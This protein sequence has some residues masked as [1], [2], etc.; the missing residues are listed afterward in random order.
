MSY[1]ERIATI[2]GGDTEQVE[3]RLC[4]RGWYERL[5]STCQSRRSDFAGLKA[6]AIGTSP[7]Q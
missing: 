3:G 1:G 2:P 6:M 7:F 5:R 4:C